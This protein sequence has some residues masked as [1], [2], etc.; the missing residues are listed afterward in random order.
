MGQGGTVYMQRSPRRGAWCGD[1]PPIIILPTGLHQGSFPLLKSPL[2]DDPPS[3]HFHV[4]LRKE[5][6]GMAS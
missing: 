2:P 4:T 1:M 6:G 3:A 5:P